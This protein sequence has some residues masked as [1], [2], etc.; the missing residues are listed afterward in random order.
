MENARKNRKL[1]FTTLF[2][3]LTLTVQ[4]FTGFTPPKGPGCACTSPSVSLTGQTSNSASFDWSPVYSAT[5]YKVWYYRKEDDFTSQEVFTSSTDISFTN[6][7]EGTY[8][9][10]FA[11]VCGGIISQVIV[12]D[13]LLMG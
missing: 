6:L 7:E 13:D 12:T 1:V 10:Y 9:F 2:F 4:V 11:T 8:E 5:E 3:L